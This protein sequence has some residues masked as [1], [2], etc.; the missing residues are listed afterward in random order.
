MNRPLGKI[1]K[2]SRTFRVGNSNKQLMF[3]NVYIF[4]IFLESPRK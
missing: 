3:L 4:D 1:M 2:A